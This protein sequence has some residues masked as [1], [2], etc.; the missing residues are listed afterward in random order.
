MRHFQNAV[1]SGSEPEHSLR[2][3]FKIV[4]RKG[5]AEAKLKNAWRDVSNMA[6]G[7]GCSVK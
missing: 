1:E 7:N 5:M 2:K 3:L 6:P 4:F